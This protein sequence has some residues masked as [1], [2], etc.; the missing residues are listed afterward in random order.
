MFLDWKI[1]IVKTRLPKAIYRFSAILIKLPMA[2]ETTDKELISKIH[3]QLMQ[4]DTRKANN[5]I[6]KW[7][8]DLKQ[9]FFRRKLTDI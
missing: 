5:L 9:K 6:K 1:N 7:A 8:E 4:L 3:N 2:N